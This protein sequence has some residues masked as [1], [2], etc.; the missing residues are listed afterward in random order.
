MK[1][2]HIKDIKLVPSLVNKEVF[3]QGFRIHH[4]PDITNFQLFRKLTIRTSFKIDCTSD[5]NHEICVELNISESKYYEVNFLLFDLFTS[6]ITIKSL[7]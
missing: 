6:Q 5:Q 4:N 2:L 7:S 1:N 3:S